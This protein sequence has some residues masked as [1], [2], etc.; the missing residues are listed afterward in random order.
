MN[1]LPVKEPTTLITDKELKE[2]LKH[3]EYS[4]DREVSYFR[5]TSVGVYLHAE[6]TEYE[7]ELVHCELWITELRVSLSKEQKDF[8]LNRLLN[9]Y[10]DIS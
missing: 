2:I 6:M 9:L 1:N 3:S 10:N 7:K 8:I 4:S 5:L